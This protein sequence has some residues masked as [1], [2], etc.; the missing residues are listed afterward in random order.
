MLNGQVVRGELFSLRESRPFGAGEGF[1]FAVPTPAL[2]GQPVPKAGGFHAILI[3][4]L[5]LK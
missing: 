5:F 3:G 1:S 2:K 4:K